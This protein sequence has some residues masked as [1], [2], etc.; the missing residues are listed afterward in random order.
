M[1]E[2]LI[3]KYRALGIDKQIELDPSNIDNYVKRQELLKQAIKTTT[4]Q[5]EEYKKR[6]ES[7]RSERGY[8]QRIEETTEE[9]DD[10]GAVCWSD[11]EHIAA[12]FNEF[13]KIKKEVNLQ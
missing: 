2:T 5:V 7:L 13:V 12:K 6:L 1:L 3:T 8:S 9:F 10:D 11:Y 4:A